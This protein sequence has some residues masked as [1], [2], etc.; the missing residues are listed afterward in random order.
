MD[1]FILEYQLLTPSNQIELL[2][3]GWRT[4]LMTNWIC[5]L[6]R[7]FFGVIF[8][9]YLYYTSFKRNNLLSEVGAISCL[10]RTLFIVI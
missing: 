8:V 4:G 3:S 2:I 5:S 7:H 9:G 10:L 1:K 6:R